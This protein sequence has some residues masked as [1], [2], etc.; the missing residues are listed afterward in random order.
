[1]CKDIHQEA[2]FCTQLKKVSKRRDLS[3]KLLESLSFQICHKR[4]LKAES[5]TL[6]AQCWIMYLSKVEG[7]LCSPI[8]YFSFCG[9]YNVCAIMVFYSNGCI[10]GIIFFSWEDGMASRDEGDYIWSNSEWPLNLNGWAGSESTPA[11]TCVFPGVGLGSSKGAHLGLGGA[12]VGVGSSARPGRDLTG[13]GA[14]GISGYAGIGAS[15]L[16]WE[17]QEDFE[18]FVDPP[19]TAEHTSTRAFSS[20]P[21]RPLFLVGST[22]THVYLWEV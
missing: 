12:T 11:P 10:Q 5:P 9:L 19:A 17:T 7:Q 22:N 4:A 15:G 1:M 13:G 3:S 20:H 21:S 2:V 16:G 6:N 8:I 18:E 14:F